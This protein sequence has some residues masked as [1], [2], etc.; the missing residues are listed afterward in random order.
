MIETAQITRQ[1]IASQTPT[2]IMT[3]QTRDSSTAV[4][5]YVP[6]YAVLGPK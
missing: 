3:G 5:Q 1:D 4:E 6:L 2:A